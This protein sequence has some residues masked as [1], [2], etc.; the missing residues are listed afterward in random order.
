M[1]LVQI[2]YQLPRAYDICSPH[3]CCLQGVVF[4][5]VSPPLPFTLDIC[6]NRYARSPK[7][8]KKSQ[9]MDDA[10]SNDLEQDG[11]QDLVGASVLPPIAERHLMS[12]KPL[13]RPYRTDDEKKVV[14]L[15]LVRLKENRKTHE[16]CAELL[17]VSVRTIVNYLVDPFYG[18]LVQE[19]QH[20]ARERGHLLISDVIGDAVEKL[21]GLM[22]TAKSEFVQ[23]KSAE[24]ILK[25][26]GYE[27]PQE[28]RERDNQ[29]D[30][31]DFLSKLDN[32]KDRKVQLNVQINTIETTNVSGSQ[33][34]ASIVESDPMSGYLAEKASQR[35]VP[36]ELERYMRPILP[37]GKIPTDEENE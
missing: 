2:N 13:G 6:M 23:Y 11:E 21:Y 15:Q 35:D 31:I 33:N 22:H 36:P 16:E 20:E 12:F 32:R 34:G 26:S 1:P 7:H 4:L 30:V 14:Y 18:E 9:L 27:V 28:Q 5:E 24:Y 25:I 10:I 29:A 37:G 3:F 17:G 19:I 8:K